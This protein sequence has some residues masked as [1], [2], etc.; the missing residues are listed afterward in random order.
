MRQQ[1]M[2]LELLVIKNQ[3]DQSLSH[4]KNMNIKII[5][6]IILDILELPK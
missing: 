6:Q 2:Q 1:K 3:S 5:S 4:E